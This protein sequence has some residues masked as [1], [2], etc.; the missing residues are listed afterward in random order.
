MVINLVSATPAQCQTQQSRTPRYLVIESVQ[1]PPDQSEHDIFYRA[2][3]MNKRPKQSLNPLQHRGDKK[4]IAFL[5]AASA[6][7]GRHFT[8]PAQGLNWT[9]TGRR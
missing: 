8:S 7:V 5:G 3:A 6:P 9:E 1:R 2:A 4:H